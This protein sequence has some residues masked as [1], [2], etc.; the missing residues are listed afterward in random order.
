[1]TDYEKLIKVLRE[2]GI[3][4][5]TPIYVQGYKY[6]EITSADYKE[7]GLEFHFNEHQEFMKII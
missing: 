7:D 1:M 2:I 3:P 5:S 4:Y 6:I